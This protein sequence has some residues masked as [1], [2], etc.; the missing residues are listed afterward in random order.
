MKEGVI[1]SGAER[2]EA[3]RDIYLAKMSN[4]AEWVPRYRSG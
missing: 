3:D 2:S 4:A 1:L